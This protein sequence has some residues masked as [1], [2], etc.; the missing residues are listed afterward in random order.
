MVM[1]YAVTLSLDPIWERRLAPKS[2]S[3]FVVRGVYKV[4]L[5]ARPSTDPKYM[6]DAWN[7]LNFGKPK[8]KLQIYRLAAVEKILDGHRSRGTH[9]ATSLKDDLTIPVMY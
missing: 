2:T 5:P 7:W 3:G 1:L 9:D 4:T 6:L 8:A